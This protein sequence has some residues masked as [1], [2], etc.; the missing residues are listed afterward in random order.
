MS[1][2][3]GS[4]SR[5]DAVAV[6]LASGPRFSWSLPRAMSSPIRALARASA[7]ALPVE[8]LLVSTELRLSIPTARSMSRDMIMM[9]DMSAKPDG[10]A[11]LCTV[12]L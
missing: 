4:V 10:L 1:E 11:T 2:V 5:M 6:A 7:T 3:V 8:A 12:F 9:V